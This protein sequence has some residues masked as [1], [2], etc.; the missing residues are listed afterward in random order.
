M[1]T[2]IPTQMIMILFLEFGGLYT[3]HNHINASVGKFLRRWI[4]LGYFILFVP[5]HKCHNRALSSQWNMELLMIG[6]KM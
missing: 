6:Q 4:F 3:N 1:H 2:F 5:M